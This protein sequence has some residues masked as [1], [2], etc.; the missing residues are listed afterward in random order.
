MKIIKKIKS[1][2]L[3]TEI[4][5][6]MKDTLF[7][8]VLTT[9]ISIFMAFFLTLFIFHSYQQIHSIKSSFVRE[10]RILADVLSANS[11]LGI[12]AGNEKLLKQEAQGFLSQSYVVG[13]SVFN[14]DSLL[15]SVTKRDEDL[16]RIAN[17]LQVKKRMSQGDTPPYIYET[18]KLM[19]IWKPV[20]VSIGFKS[21]E[22][23]V[24]GIMPTKTR[25]AGWV[26]LSLDKSEILKKER[27]Y[28]LYFLVT[29]FI[30]ISLAY[31]FMHRAALKTVGAI[32]ILCEHVDS[33]K[34]IENV[35]ALQEIPME[36]ED[37]AGRVAKLINEM[38][39]V[40][41]KRH[42]E[43]KKLETQL[44]NAQKLEA[45]GALAGGIAHDFNNVL[46]SVMGSGDIVKYR[47]SEGQEIDPKFV[48]AIIT[49]S[50]RAREMIVELL[51][52]ARGKGMDRYPLKLNDQITM[53]KKM[54]S[55]FLSDD[56]QI[57]LEL[58][59]ED[60]VVVSNATQLH[61]VLLNMLTNAQDAMPK[62]G[63][64]RIATGTAQISE[65][66]AKKKGEWVNPGRY[67]V[68][69]IEDTGIGMDEEVMK[70]IFK[71]F[72]TTKG[73]EKGTG[74]GLYNCFKIV[75]EHGGFIDVESEKGKGTLFK[76]YIPLS[77][78]KEVVVEK[79]EDSLADIP[80]GSGTILVA[81]DDPFVRE[82][83]KGILTE[84]GYEVILA[85]NGIDV[86]N[87]FRDN[88]DKVD[89]V[90]MDI[91]MPY[92]HGKSAQEEIRKM[93]PEVKILFMSGYPDYVL[94]EKGISTDDIEY[95][96]KPIRAATLI[97]KI[98]QVLKS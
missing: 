29:L 47:I 60:P 20:Y 56:I 25:L 69:Y 4:Y 14:R 17:I 32:D 10:A 28:L 7:K 75:K 68:I 80:K 90:L 57:N 73:S 65:H 87:K 43:K 54:A 31:F 34:N 46:A 30:C 3:I 84:F 2:P 9:F 64:L 24:L 72:F 67:G 51:K 71:P 76:I 50:K 6:Q 49:C 59:E 89:L 11:R 38:I 26:A 18:D 1:F 35:E 15:M 5:F 83:I 81:D 39:R 66:V 93:K 88:M 96:Q 77:D 37:E 27:L 36:G 86:I 91:V 21:A 85:V 22:E 82:V 8:K 19:E 97:K 41:K 62:G 45:I 95:L 92:K 70:N 94:A 98:Q 63:K 58:S 42:E 79:D 78:T 74:L 16:P 13:I 53:L 12:L 44:L 61:Q 33:F 40:L 23:M 52:Y 48:D 55:G